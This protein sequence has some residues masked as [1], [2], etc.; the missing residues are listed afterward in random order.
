VHNAITLAYSFLV[1]SEWLR[2]N[3]LISVEQT[4]SRNGKKL[5]C[6]FKEYVQSK[7][8]YY[9]KKAYVATQFKHK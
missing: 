4:H 8:S 3:D 6:G 1:R 9:K 2:T 5:S 7:M